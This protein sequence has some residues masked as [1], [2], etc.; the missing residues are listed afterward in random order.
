MHFGQLCK[1]FGLLC[2]L[3][4]VKSASYTKLCVL[5][6]QGSLYLDILA[7]LPGLVLPFAVLA[8][9]AMPQALLQIIVLLRLLRLL[10][11][12]QIVGKL[13]KGQMGTKSAGGRL[14]TARQSYMLSLIYC[15]VVTVHLLACLWYAVANY[16]DTVPKDQ[17]WL[18]YAS[19]RDLTDSPFVERYLAALYFAVRKQIKHSVLHT[20]GC[21]TMHV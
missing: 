10:R 17:T 21:C 9:S 18:G 8:G 15:L 3:C 6:V 1:A 14:M 16:N 19:G 4:C 11:V 13:S 12:L 20:A 7:A 2:E 5:I